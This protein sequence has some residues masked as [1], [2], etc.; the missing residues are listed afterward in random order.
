MSV[1]FTSGD[2]VVNYT[3]KPSSLV[4]NTDICIIPDIEAPVA[5]AYAMLRKG[6]S[7]PF[8]DAETSLDEVDARIVE[9]SSTVD[10]NSGDI[11][12]TLDY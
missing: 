9:M 1:L 8:E 5:Y 3:F 6:E 4:N 12:F 2:Y 11:G 7:D 10:N